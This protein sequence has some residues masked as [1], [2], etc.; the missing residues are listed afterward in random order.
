VNSRA[1]NAHAVLVT[2]TS[3]CLTMHLLPPSDAKIASWVSL[4]VKIAALLYTSS[5]HCMLLR[6][7]LSVVSV[8]LLCTISY[9]SQKWNG[10]HFEGATLARI[11]LRVQLGH[12]PG[13]R[14]PNPK[15]G[16]H[17]FTVIHTNGLHRVVVDYCECDNLA[18]AGSR[19]QQLLRRE[20]YPAT[21]TEPQTCCT[22]RVLQHFHMQTLQ[23]KIMA[24]NYYSALEK[25]TDNTGMV[26][27]K[28]SPI[29]S[30]SEEE[31]EHFLGSIQGV[32][33][34]N[35]RVASPK[36]AQTSRSR[37]HCHR[38]KWNPAW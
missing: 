19:R 8:Y 6:C 20:W 1:L 18:N 11:G 32:H 25:L 21:H 10:E 24:Y 34:C 26:P 17:D 12:P 7:A 2:R 15:A 5:I 28:V 35:A 30:F 33:A 16:H 4:F 31:S 36:N 38:L 23:G 13:V 37:A 29:D 9:I 27:L 3:T 14:C 22:F